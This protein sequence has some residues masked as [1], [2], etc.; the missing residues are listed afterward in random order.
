M[1]FINVIKYYGFFLRT[2]KFTSISRIIFVVKYLQHYIDV[3]YKGN[4]RNNTFS[5]SLNFLNFFIKILYIYTY[6]NRISSSISRLYDHFNP[7]FGQF[8]HIGRRKRRSPLPYGL[9]FSPYGYNFPGL[10]KNLK[11]Y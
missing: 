6:L 9:I 3:L 10:G 5:V 7:V 8:G 2:V 4:S 11:A 1:Y